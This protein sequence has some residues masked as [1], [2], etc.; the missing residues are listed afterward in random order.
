MAYGFKCGL[1]RPRR[2]RTGG[3]DEP[4]RPAKPVKINDSRACGP[5]IYPQPYPHHT[6]AGTFGWSAR[7]LPIPARQTPYDHSGWRRYRER[8]ATARLIALRLRRQKSGKPCRLT[9]TVLG[10]LRQR[11]EKPSTPKAST[12]HAPGSSAAARNRSWPSG[13]SQLQL[14]LGEKPD[15]DTTDSELALRRRHQYSED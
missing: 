13:E 10:S 8:D 11:S 12:P 2:K 15:R 4:K 14:Y 7:I 1:E 3:A 6:R 5:S 9:P